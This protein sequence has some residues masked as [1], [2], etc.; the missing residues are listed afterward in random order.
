MNKNSSINRININEKRL[1]DISI[2][3]TNRQKSLKKFKFY[4]KELTLLNRYYGSPNWFK[5]KDS[6]ENNLLPK[7]KA[8]V[9]SEDA[10]WNLNEEISELLNEMKSIINDYK[11]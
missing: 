8:G 11:K 6:Y 4:K 1:D 5:D 7:V 3:V 9:L 2:C 10:I